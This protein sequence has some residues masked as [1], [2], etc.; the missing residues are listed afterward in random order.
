MNKITIDS[1]TALSL[2]LPLITLVVSLLLSSFYTG[3]DQVFYNKLYDTLGGMDFVS[4]FE[5]YQLHLNKV[6]VVYFIFTWVGG[7]LGF[8]K[9]SWFTLI[10]VV[11]SFFYVCL[12][13]RLGFSPFVIFLFFVTNFYFYVL[14]FAADRL[15]FGFLFLILALTVSSNR[16]RYV[17]ILASVV[18]HVQML[19]LHSSFISIYISEKYKSKS[20]YLLNAKYFIPIAIIVIPLSIYI[21]GH[22]ANKIVSYIDNGGIQSVAKQ[23]VF[24]VFSMY[25][26]R[27]WLKVIFAYFPILVVSFIIGDERVTMFS[28]AI[29]MYFSL[30]KNRGL[31]IPTFILMS[32]FGFKS[33]VFVDRVI[34]TGSG[35]VSVN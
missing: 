7:N 23:L 35:F 8:D 28:Y 29:F 11:F 5:Y 22:V 17:L 14:F 18:G 33:I 31:N 10:N 2:L 4:A 1:N 15:K 32:Y 20:F 27:N 3:G 24:V 21:S 13:R 34:S 26:C 30:Y 6:E 9:N 19:I 25:C 16:N 12:F